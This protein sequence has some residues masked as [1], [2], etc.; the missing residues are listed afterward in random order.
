MKQA[1]TPQLRTAR[2]R[3]ARSLCTIAIRV[4]SVGR[5]IGQPAALHPTPLRSHGI[6]F[7]S[8]ALYA[9]A[10]GCHVAPRPVCR[11]VSRPRLHRV[12]HRNSSA[13]RRGAVPHARSSCRPRVCS[14]RLRPP[15]A[16]AWS[17]RARSR[18]CLAARGAEARSPAPTAPAQM[19][20]V[21]HR[22]A[23]SAVPGRDLSERG[24]QDGHNRACLAACRLRL[25]PAD[26][27]RQIDADARYDR[28]RRHACC[29]LYPQATHLPL[30]N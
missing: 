11:S 4:Q 8:Q 6:A 19:F 13:A 12:L 20:P 22:P 23:R 1:G 3:A 15:L 14:R 9:C 29:N 2:R 26:C 25:R 5:A 17:R 28:P 10:A 7:R 18:R 30:V 27:T 24:A 21:Q 16:P